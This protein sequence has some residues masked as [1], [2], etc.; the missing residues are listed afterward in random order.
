MDKDLLRSKLQ[1]LLQYVGSIK[2]QK[3]T[4]PEGL[5]PNS[6]K[7]AV[8]ILNWSNAMQMCVDMG[9]ILLVNCGMQYRDVR[10][11][12]LQDTIF[13]MNIRKLI[14]ENLRDKLIDDIKFRNKAIHECDI[15]S[16]QEIVQKVQNNLSDFAEFAKA[17]SAL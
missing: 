15:L 2:S 9:K 11:Q 10:S 4:S 7:W 6:Y 1:M 12:G 5:E 14:L 13:A 8:V 17:V 3:V 16:S